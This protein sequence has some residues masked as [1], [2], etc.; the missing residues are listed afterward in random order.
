MTATRADPS[1]FWRA[2]PPLTSVTSPQP[3]MPQRM[4][5]FVVQGVGFVASVFVAFMPPDNGGSGRAN[6]WAVGMDVTRVCNPLPLLGIMLGTR[7]GN[8]CH[9]G[10]GTAA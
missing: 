8:P 6:Q 7:V 3:M 1:A 5:S 2:G 4:V 9:G 10:C